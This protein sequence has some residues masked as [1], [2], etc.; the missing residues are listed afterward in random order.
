ME[1]KLDRRVRMTQKMLRE[2]LVRLMQTKPISRITVKELCAQADVNRGTFYAHY[3]SQYDLLRQ[4][5]REVI[6]DV[7]D[8]MNT[9]GYGLRPGEPLEVVESVVDYIRKNADTF[10]VLLCMENG[11]RLLEQIQAVVEERFV[12]PGSDKAALLGSYRYTFITCGVIGLL[13]RWLESGM[14]LSAADMAGLIVGQIEHG[15][16]A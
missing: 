1:K 8:Y 10:R 16:Y 9:I 7:Q 14:S 11:G 6:S 12:Q 15:L 13:R 2:S 4:L 3:A 5:E